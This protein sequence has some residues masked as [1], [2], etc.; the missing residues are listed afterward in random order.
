MC[1]GYPYK[2]A[3]KDFAIKTHLIKR[4]QRK[5]RALKVDRHL[6]ADCYAHLA[7]EANTEA[8]KGAD[9][10]DDSGTPITETTTQSV[11][12]ATISAALPG[13]PQ[14]RY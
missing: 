13:A 1:D 9:L 7:L 8:A 11:D 3:L 10:R 2:S 6:L 12:M 14:M 5:S 4:H